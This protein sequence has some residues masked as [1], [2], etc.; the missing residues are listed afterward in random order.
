MAI[1]S[2]KMF[3][4][5]ILSIA[6]NRMSTYLLWLS[7]ECVNL[8]FASWRTLDLISMPVKRTQQ[9]RRSFVISFPV[10]LTGYL[11]LN[12]TMRKIP[13]GLYVWK[14]HI[15]ASLLLSIQMTGVSQ[16][17]STSSMLV[18]SQKVKSVS[19]TRC[20]TWVSS[21]IDRFNAIHLNSPLLLQ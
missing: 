11:K 3:Q 14:H 5:S 16:K 1:W 13:L 9:L 6:S 18:S 20:S 17:V 4:P 21:S 7:P 12:Q 2:K 19:K 8:V 15:H 10:F